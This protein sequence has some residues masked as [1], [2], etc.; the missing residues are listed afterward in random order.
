MDIALVCFEGFNEIDSFVALTMFRRLDRADWT[1]HITAP[2]ETITSLSGVRMERQKPLSFAREADV[3]IVGSG[4]STRTVVDDAALMAELRFDPGRQ[5]IAGQCSG[6]LIL[7]K[8]G[9]LRDVSVCTDVITKPWVQAAGARVVEQP[10]I[11]QGNV[12]T[13]G[14]CLASHYLATWIIARKLGRADAERALYYVAPVGEQAEWVA[15][16]FAAVGPY[17]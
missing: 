1:A 4:R 6:S 11:A 12:A 16:A 13:V 17:L 15:R 7:A 5:L 2:K 14:G 10:F 8:L 9:H 3:V